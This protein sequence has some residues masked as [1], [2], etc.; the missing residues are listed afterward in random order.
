MFVSTGRP[1]V[2]ARVPMTPL[3]TCAST[4]VR[5]PSRNVASVMY[6]ARSW[7]MAVPDRESL[8]TGAD[9]RSRDRRWR[10]AP[11]SATVRPADR[12]LRQ[13]SVPHAGTRPHHRSDTQC[14]HY[15]LACGNERAGTGGSDDLVADALP[16]LRICSCLLYVAGAQQCLCLV[17]PHNVEMHQAALRPVSDHRRSPSGDRCGSP[18]H[19]AGRASAW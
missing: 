14:G 9:H 12:S 5:N 2:A 1:F 4:P 18:P 8:W 10:V 16:L 3:H 11:Q 7:M 13:A 15:S 19:S 17:I 6:W